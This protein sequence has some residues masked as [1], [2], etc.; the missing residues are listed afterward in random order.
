MALEMR[1]A[2][3]NANH[4]HDGKHAQPEHQRAP[5]SVVCPRQSDEQRPCP[6]VCVGAPTRRADRAGEDIELN[7]PRAQ[8]S[9][10]LEPR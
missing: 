9:A 10:K 7:G 5:A 6:S 3:G 8:V 1:D 2:V 4:D